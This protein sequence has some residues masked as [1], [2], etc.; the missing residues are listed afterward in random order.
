MIVAVDP[1]LLCVRTPV[2][3]E[4]CM[5]AYLSGFFYRD[6]IGIFNRQLL[7]AVTVWQSE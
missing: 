2:F 3:D 4:A 7:T 6:L 1:S 5:K